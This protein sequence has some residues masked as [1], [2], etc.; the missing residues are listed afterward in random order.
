[1]ETILDQYKTVRPADVTNWY[2]AAKLAAFPKNGGACINIK[3]NKSLF[4]LLIE[5]ANGMP[6]RIYVHTKWK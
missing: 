2:K 5:R 6:V 4:I 3:T 1:M